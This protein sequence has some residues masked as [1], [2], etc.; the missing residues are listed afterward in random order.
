MISR[1]E[2][3]AVLEQ[4]KNLAWSA[5]TGNAANPLRSSILDA[6]FARIEQAIDQYCA[7]PLDPFMYVLPCVE[8]CTP[9]QHAYHQGQ[10][11]MALRI[12]EELAKKVSQDK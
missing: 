9:E 8:D 7:E 1:D 6:H 5:A 4:E 12:E 3:R 11:D 2:L 10:W